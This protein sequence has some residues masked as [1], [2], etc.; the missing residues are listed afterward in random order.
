M[1]TKTN[2]PALEPMTIDRADLPEVPRHRS[3]VGTK[4]YWLGLTEDCPLQDATCGGHSIPKWTGQL[5]R[6]PDDPNA[7][8][9]GHEPRLGQIYDL[10]PDEVERIVAAV[11][12]RVV[13]IL[14]ASRDESKYADAPGMSPR[15][16]RRG[17]LYLVD[18][19]HYTAM[20]GDRPLSEFAYIVPLPGL[21]PQDWR[22]TT[23][24]TLVPS[25]A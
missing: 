6:D 7:W 11:K 2:E 22:L 10:H 9:L 13:R 12:A 5:M 24:A 18:H 19:P 21:L 20:P 14:G 23:P 17:Q 25:G 3:R 4:R 1:N 15:R 8:A 16:V